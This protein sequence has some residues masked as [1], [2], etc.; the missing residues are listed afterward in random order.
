V[1]FAFNE[2]QDALRA[3]V[4]QTL[5][6]E[7]DREALIALGDDERGFTDELWSVIAGSGW[8]GLLVA[9]EHGGLGLGLVD[10]VVVLEEM[11][12]VP[13]PG[14]YLSSAVLATLAARALGADDLL[15][16]LADGSTRGTLALDEVG[17]R[18]PLA[19]VVVTATRDGDGWVLDGIK[20]AVP[21]GHTA[22]WA[23]VVARDDTGLAGFL[24]E[25]PHATAVPSMDPLRKLARLELSAAPARRLGPD[26]NQTAILRRIADDAAVALAAESVGS[27]ERA[28]EL[29]VEYSHVREQFGRPIGAFQAIRHKAAEMLEA[30]ELA[31]VGAH[32]AAWTSDEDRPEREVAAAMAKSWVAEAAIHVTGE[33][34]QIHGAVGF[35]WEAEPHWHYRRA[36]VNDLL[37]GQQG[38][39]RQRVADLILGPVA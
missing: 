16:G 7:I 28:L 24:V 17:A 15:P 11:G 19:S 36:K 10:L 33:S 35:T 31:R 13:M 23:I 34:I 21:D 32:Y 5:A 25:Q 37:L 27:A 3:A 29:A 14:P 22:D 39:Q 30:V 8:T 26:G 9:E 4:R 18:D 20:P 2:E 6:S 38:W 1:D 12:R